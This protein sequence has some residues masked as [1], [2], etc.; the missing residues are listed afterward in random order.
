VANLIRFPARVRDFSSLQIVKIGFEAQPLF[1]S[2]YRD[3]G[4]GGDTGRNVRMATFPK[5]F[6]IYILNCGLFVE[7]DFGP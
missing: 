5:E 7:F 2:V 1:L 3:E 4:G 6:N